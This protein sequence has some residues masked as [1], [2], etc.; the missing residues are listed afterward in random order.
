M[1]SKPEQGTKST[2]SQETKSEKPKA[3]PKVSKKF[4]VPNS[5]GYHLGPKN[6]S[7]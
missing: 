3:E 1:V 6:P 7:H 4:P 2:K 5:D